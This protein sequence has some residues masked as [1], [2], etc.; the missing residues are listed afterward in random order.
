MYISVIIFDK[1]M[2]CFSFGS[3]NSIFFMYCFAIYSWNN[4][5]TFC[6]YIIITLINI[7]IYM[8]VTI[9]KEI[10]PNVTTGFQMRPFWQISAAKYISIYICACVHTCLRVCLGYMY[11]S[12]W[13]IEYEP[14]FIVFTRCLPSSINYKHIYTNPAKYAQFFL[15]FVIVVI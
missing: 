4:A 6:N 15:I 9:L 8:I 7:Y 3:N 10:L 12:A 13:W 11:T 1:S 14:T 5:V 2:N